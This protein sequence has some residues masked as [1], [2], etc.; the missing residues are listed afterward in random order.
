MSNI[1]DLLEKYFEGQTSAKEEATLRRFFT[2][3][4]VPENLAMYKPLFAYFDDEIKKMEVVNENESL[5]EDEIVSLPEDDNVRR[6]E[7][8]NDNKDCQKVVNKHTQKSKKFV[9]WLSGAAACAAILIGTFTITPQ[10]KKCH[11]EGDYVIIDGR[12]Y[13]D[14]HTIRKSM[15]NSLQEMSD[16][17]DD[18]TEEKTSDAYNASEASGATRIIENQLKEFD[19]L[20]DE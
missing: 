10:S 15:L 13:T 19:F 14:V 4:D 6:L 16:Y 9:L 8:E 3:G 12:C 2:S 1:E 5:P 18:F 17:R 20:L 11:G 7:I